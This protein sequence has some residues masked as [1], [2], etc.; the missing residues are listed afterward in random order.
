MRACVTKTILSTSC[1]RTLYDKIIHT[2]GWA[3]WTCAIHIDKWFGMKT[4][5]KKNKPYRL[6]YCYTRDSVVRG[7][8]S[9][10]RARDKEI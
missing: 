2:A 5:D 8:T 6:L 7:R 1:R 3:M 4:V 10:P 9:A